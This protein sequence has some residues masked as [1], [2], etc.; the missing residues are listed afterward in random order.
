M[1]SHSHTMPAK[2]MC[3]EFCWAYIIISKMVRTTFKM[4]ENIVGF[5]LKLFQFAILI[6]FVWLFSFVPWQWCDRSKRNPT[7]N[8][9]TQLA[10]LLISRA[11]CCLELNYRIWWMCHLC[12]TKGL[13]ILN[14]VALVEGA[15][16]NCGF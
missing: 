4:I 10:S 3:I 13:S 6:S 16:D 11:E 15:N 12:S 7:R 2:L 9:K 8:K 14:R 1:L 5:I